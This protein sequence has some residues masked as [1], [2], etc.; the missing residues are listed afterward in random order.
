MG[1]R[2]K[3]V[4]NLHRWTQVEFA[5]IL[6]VHQSTVTRLEQGLLEPTDELL[7]RIEEETGFFAKIL[8][9][10]SRTSRDSSGYSSLSKEVKALG[11]R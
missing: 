11:R 8:S 3:R 9:E 4:R 10:G 6:G 7:R 5:R 2:F 1:P